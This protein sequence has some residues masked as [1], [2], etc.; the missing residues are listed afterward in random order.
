MDRD[1][2][3][4]RGPSA[5]GATRACVHLD[6]KLEDSVQQVALINQLYM[7][8]Q[9]IFNHSLSVGPDAQLLDTD[10]FPRSENGRRIFMG[11]G[12]QSPGFVS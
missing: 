7:D 2:T 6:A 1:L 5:G 11:L 9:S 8:E 4:S 10:I 3:D 12:S